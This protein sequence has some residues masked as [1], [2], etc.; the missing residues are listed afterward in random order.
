MT[1]L[2]PPYLLGPEG[3]SVLKARLETRTRRTPLVIPCAAAVDAL[4][5]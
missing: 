5:V 3:D 1:A 4:L 2:A